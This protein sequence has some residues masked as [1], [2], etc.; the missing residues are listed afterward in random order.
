VATYTKRKVQTEVSAQLS[1]SYFAFVESIQRVEVDRN[2]VEAQAIRE[3][4][5]RA[6]YNNGLITF[7]AWDLIENDFIAR[8]KAILASEQNRIVAEASWENAQGVG[9]IP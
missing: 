2:F 5:A 8:Q 7:F 6:Q 1:A 3:K 4:I 9:V